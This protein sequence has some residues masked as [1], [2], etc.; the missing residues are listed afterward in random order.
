MYPKLTTQKIG[1]MWRAFKKHQTAYYVALTCG[2]SETT[3]RKYIL[4]HNFAT[5]FAKLQARANEI[6][7]E[8][9]AQSLA[10]AIKNSANINIFIADALLDTLKNKTFK[11]GTAD[12][13]RMVRLERYLRGEPDSRTEQ[14][15]TFEWLEVDK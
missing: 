4:N 6:V 12:Y 14:G 3:A 8:D 9:Q 13:D 15:G 10:R 7:D 11:P 5:R 2:I 1:A